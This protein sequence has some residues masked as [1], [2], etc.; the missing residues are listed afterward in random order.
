[1]IHVIFYSYC[2]DQLSKPQQLVVTFAGGYV[3]GI[4][5]TLV[6]HPF[7]SIVSKLNSDVGSTPIRAARELGMRGERIAL[8]IRYS[9]MYIHC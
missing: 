6:S 9:L 2:R 7:D 8:H 1:M 4:F 5:C 3:A